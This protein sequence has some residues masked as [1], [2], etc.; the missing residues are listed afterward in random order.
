MGVGVG[1]ARQCYKQ[2]IDQAART[3]APVGRFLELSYR[4]TQKA[5]CTHLIRRFLSQL[6]SS[7]GLLCQSPT[8]SNFLAAE[9][10]RSRVGPVRMCS[11]GSC[12]AFQ[13][14]YPT[15]WVCNRV[16]AYPCL[17]LHIPLCIASRKSWNKTID[18]VGSNHS[19]C[20]ISSE[21]LI[22][23]V[24]LNSALVTVLSCRW[25][26]LWTKSGFLSQPCRVC[27]TAPCVQKERTE[28]AAQAKM[29]AETTSILLT[30][31]VSIVCLTS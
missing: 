17:L 14:L 31:H 12:N 22:T 9:D 2:G 26:G 25:E 8:Y 4:H 18:L 29:T 3:V 1:G 11:A 7:P 19:A 21:C 16:Y 28:K 6:P 30:K 13:S 24:G 27:S 20:S 23:L 10:L 5:L 15:T